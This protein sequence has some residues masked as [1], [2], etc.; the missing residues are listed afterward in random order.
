MMSRVSGPA[1]ADIPPEVEAI[2]ITVT[3]AGYD[4]LTLCVVRL[5]TNLTKPHATAASKP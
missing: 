3:K 2:D 5:L 1:T 4:E